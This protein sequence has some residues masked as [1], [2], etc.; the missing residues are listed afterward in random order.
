MIEFHRVTL[1][2]CDQAR[3][4]VVVIDVLR[5]FTTAAFAFDA[6]AEAIILVSTLEQARE[7]KHHEPHLMLTGEDGGWKP[8]DFE[9]GNS[10]L[11]FID[12]NL[13]GVRLVQRTSAGTQGVVRTSNAEDLF[14][15]SLCCARGTVEAL[16]T[17][18][19]ARVSF[20]LT[21]VREG[22]FG[23][24]DAACADY[25]ESL[26]CSEPVNLEL[27]RERVRSSGWGLRFNDPQYPF[28]DDRDLDY[29]LQVDRFPFAMRIEKSG[30]RQIMRPEFQAPASNPG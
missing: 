29:C 25:L 17:L 1:E 9:F 6:G 4:V 8:A 14:A 3:G 26:L 28:L 30:D 12:Q 23:D 20:V 16:R 11:E 15:A 19:P 18:N 27:I 2:N 13:A 7:M 22:G 10:P 24:E 21:G 5:A